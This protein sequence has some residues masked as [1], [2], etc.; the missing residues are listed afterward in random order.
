MPR[1]DDAVAALYKFSGLG[2][3]AAMVRKRTR[4]RSVRTG[5]SDALLAE[6]K[7]VATDLGIRVREEKLLRGV[8]YRVRGGGCRLHDQDLVFLDR[9]W[10]VTRRIDV[11]LDEL[12]QRDVDT[13]TLPPAA[14]RLFAGRYEGV[15]P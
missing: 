9:T 4:G 8:G 15:A 13:R 2:H 10:P 3:N 14:R 11:L 12:V 5:K 1:E 6:L 7:D